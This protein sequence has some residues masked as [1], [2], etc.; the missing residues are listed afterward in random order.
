MRQLSEGEKE[1]FEDLKRNFDKHVSKFKKEKE[2][3]LGEG[4]QEELKLEL[5][6]LQGYEKGHVSDLQINAA[7]SFAKLG[8][9][10]EL[11]GKSK[12]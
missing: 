8:V 12:I 4:K 11:L 3:Q 6:R 10:K 5:K 7:F 1:Y 2:K 9:L